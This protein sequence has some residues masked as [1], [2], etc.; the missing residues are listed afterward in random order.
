MTTNQRTMYS[1]YPIKN[2]PRTEYDISYYYES[3][4]I[5]VQIYCIKICHIQSYIHF[6][7]NGGSR[8]HIS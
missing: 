5:F 6:L 4:H 7:W 1:L 3:G 2:Q 8:L